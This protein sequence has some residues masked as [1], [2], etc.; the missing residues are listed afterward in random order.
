[1]LRGN[2]GSALAGNLPA[3]TPRLDNRH[4]QARILESARRRSPY[5]AAPD[6]GYV[7]LDIACKLWER[8]RSRRRVPKT[9]A[10]CRNHV[11]NPSNISVINEL[12]H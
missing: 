7:H 6:N 9:F 12:S 8:G 2:L 5:D 4:C 10:A 3:D 1:V 11:P